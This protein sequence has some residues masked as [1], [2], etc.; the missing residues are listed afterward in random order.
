MICMNNSSFIYREIIKEG[1]C[2]YS[3]LFVFDLQ[4]V[5]SIMA[6]YIGG[7]FIHSNG[8]YWGVLGMFVLMGESL[9][10]YCDHCDI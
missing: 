9:I 5:L 10:G 7:S 1:L 4:K 3:L 2:I 8:I 6:A